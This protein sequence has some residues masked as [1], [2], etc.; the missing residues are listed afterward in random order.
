M[1]TTKNTVLV[2]KKF[3]NILFTLAIFFSSCQFLYNYNQHLLEL[4]YKL[5]WAKILLAVV[6]PIVVTVIH[7]LIN[8]DL[9]YIADR[10]ASV[11]IIYT[12]LYIIDSV[13]LRNTKL[14][15]GFLSLRQ[16]MYGLE[17]FFSVL[18]V[19]TLITLI[20]QKDRELNNHYAESLK[21]F[22]SGSIPVMVI[23]FAKIYFS[24]RIYGKVYNPPNLIP[25]NGEMSEFAKSGELELLIRDAG[26]VLF[27][28][29][30]VI[31]LLGITKRCKFFWGICLPVAISVSMEFYQ[32]FFK[33]GDP[34]IDDVILN[35]VGAI[36][37]CVIYKFIIE[38]IKENELCWESLEQWMWR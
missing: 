33:C 7:Y 6:V 37:G 3:S 10:T 27:F 16:L 26:N 30:L 29:A 36:L 17:T 24:S 35:T 15:D 23:G 1:S 28:T 21:A 31:V 25:F 13:I 2:I 9:I 34:D 32:Y 12:F 5:R 20:R 18:A 14:I 19:I 4:N 11:M 38:K 8:H 22:F